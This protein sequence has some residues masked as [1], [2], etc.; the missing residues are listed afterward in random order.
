MQNTTSF[1]GI[2]SGFDQLAMTQ[3]LLLSCMDVALQASQ[4]QPPRS[5]IDIGVSTMDDK[6]KEP[7]RSSD[8][9][10]N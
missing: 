10:D 2:R 9:T 6:V 8:S 4:I 3:Q 1:N 5:T 7:M